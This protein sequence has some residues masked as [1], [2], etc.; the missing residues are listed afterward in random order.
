MGT[1]YKLTRAPWA[2]GHTVNVGYL[3]PG[4]GCVQHMVTLYGGTPPCVKHL[5]RVV[6]QL[7]G[8]QQ[9]KRVSLHA[10]LAMAVD[11]TMA[12]HGQ[13]MA[14]YKHGAPARLPVPLAIRAA[15]THKTRAGMVL[16]PCDSMVGGKCSGRDS[17][18]RVPYST[19]KQ[20]WA[21]ALWLFPGKQRPRLNMAVQHA[22]AYTHSQLIA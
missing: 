4:N 19:Y 8:K 7:Y 21:L 22:L 2:G 16:G 6:A 12:Y 18:S 17:I 14:V 15:C 3:A 10:A 11:Q 13:Q 5:L 9:G 1:N 20:L